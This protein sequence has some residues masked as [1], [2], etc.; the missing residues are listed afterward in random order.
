[1]QAAEQV[2]LCS[3]AKL[4]QAM[5]QQMIGTAEGRFFPAWSPAPR[6]FRQAVAGE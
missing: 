4:S 5:V 1:M 2:K 6:R 3:D